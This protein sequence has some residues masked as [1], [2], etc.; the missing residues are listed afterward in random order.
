M[1]QWM[2]KYGNWLALVFAALLIVADQLVKQWALSVLQPLRTIPVW[3]GVFQFTYVENTGAAF[4]VLQGEQFILV[5]VTGVLILVLAVAVALKKI[6]SPWMQWCFALIIGGGVGN[7]ID[8]VVLGYVVDYLQ[9]TFITFPVF[10]LADCF[11]VIG[12]I[13]FVIGYLFLDKGQPTVS[14]KSSETTVPST[15]VEEQE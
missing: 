5:G 10:N 3:D 1:K 6:P 7:L 13:I 9:V 8:R 4:G 2:Q 11:V 12:A 14:E 15:T